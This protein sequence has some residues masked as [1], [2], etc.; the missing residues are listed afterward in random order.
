MVA[1]VVTAAEEA[2]VEKAVIAAVIIIIVITA[3]R[4]K[5]LLLKIIN[6]KVL[7]LLLLLPNRL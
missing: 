3:G 4:I 2:A 7:R 1:V 5:T 6:L